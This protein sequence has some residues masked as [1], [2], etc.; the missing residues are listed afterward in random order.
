MENIKSL[1]TPKELAEAIGASES[2]LRRWVD[3][4]QIRM[5]RT[6][7]GHRRIPLA[8]A[9]QFIRK[10]GATVVRPEMLGFADVVVDS[11]SAEQSDEEKLFELLNAADRASVRALLRG[12][13]LEGRNLPEIF[14]GPVRLAMH[15]MGELWHHEDRGILIEHRATDICIEAIALMREFLPAVPSTA[16]LALGG[17]PA[18]DPYLLPSM[19]AGAVLAEAGYRD[20][21]FGANTPLEL[22]GREAT[23]RRA[24]LVWLSISSCKDPRALLS[25]IQSLATTLSEQGIS[26]VIGGRY[27]AECTPR[28]F[29]NVSPA[30]SM[31]ELAAYARGLLHAGKAVDR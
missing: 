17:G 13:Y 4:G 1:L 20:G 2:S 25:E 12:W 26:L 6:A 30:A 28:G 5:S 16:P 23:Q 19:M 29:S 31:S 8:E 27:H 24:R 15:R 3:S 10:S 18:N 22:L 7:G 21:N 9:I 11:R 14:D